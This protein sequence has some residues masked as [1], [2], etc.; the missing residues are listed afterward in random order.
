[1]C[2][3]YE[4]IKCYVVYGV[5]KIVILYYRTNLIFLTDHH[6]TAGDPNIYIS[7]AIKS[8]AGDVNFKS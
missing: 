6:Q 8:D 4:V 7:V 5:V 2:A 1:M 3:I